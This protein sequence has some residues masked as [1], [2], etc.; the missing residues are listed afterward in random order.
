[1]RLMSCFTSPS[2]HLVEHLGEDFDLT[3]QV[4]LE[5][6]LLVLA[7]ADAIPACS[8]QFQL[9]SEVKMRA[10]APAAATNIPLSR[11][12]GRWSAH[13]GCVRP[14]PVT[15]IVA[16]TAIS[17]PPKRFRCAQRP[18]RSCPF[19]PGRTPPWSPRRRRGAATTASGVSFLVTPSAGR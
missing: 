12:R 6:G 1:M 2:A 14:H 16:A 4:V 3:L 8:A 5:V 13:D 19:P 18:R 9:V 11:A 15:S 10:M 7:V 17:V